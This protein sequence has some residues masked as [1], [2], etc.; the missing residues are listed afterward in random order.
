M[1]EDGIRGG[2]THAIH[3][4]AEANNKYMK[5]YDKNK[6][7]SYLLY[8]DANNLYGWALS[9]K[10]PVDSFK[11]VKNVSMLDEKFIKDYCKDSDIRYILEVDIKYPKNLHDL[12]SDASFLRE[13]MKIN[14]FNKLV[15]NL[16]D[17][18]SYVVHIRTLKQALNHGLV[19][20]KKC[21]KQSHFIRKHGLNHILI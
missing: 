3:K 17:K 15:C 2:I 13:R 19:F 1:M 11:C 9:Q 4:H 12:H 6:E 20:K 16:H 14:K 5:N 21:I 18:K 8:L 10:L 7:S